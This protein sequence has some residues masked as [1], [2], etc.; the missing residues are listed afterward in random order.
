MPSELLPI[1]AARATRRG[2][3]DEKNLSGRQ[4][5]LEER[6]GPMSGAIRRN[7]L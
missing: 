4:G 2:R 1:G 7:N 3:R 5:V 6:P